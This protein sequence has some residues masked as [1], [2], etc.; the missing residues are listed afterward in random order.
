MSI[1][2]NIEKI[3]ERIAKA[4]LRS[5]RKREEINLMAVSKFHNRQMVD[6]AYKA[7]IRYFGEN[8]VQEAAAKFGD[9]RE[10]YP[11]AELH[12]IGAL[13]RNKAKLAVSLFD[14]IQ[15]IDREGIVAELAKAGRSCPLPV[16][17]EFRTGEDSKSGFTS[18]DELFRVVELILTYPSLAICG[19]MTI[20]PNTREETPVRLAFRQLAKMRRELEQRF[21][22][23]GAWSWLSMGMTGDFE[24]AVEEGSTFLRIGSA[25]FGEWA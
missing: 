8:R 9:F 20:A 21:P 3:E 4:C 10:K 18:A 7:G 13:Q 14:C 15:S 1:T 25:I 2:A 6:E 23:D 24:I 22:G 17:L 11:G 5:G 16:L 12:L 19:L